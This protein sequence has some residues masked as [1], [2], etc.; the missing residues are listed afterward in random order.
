MYVWWLRLN[1]QFILGPIPLPCHRCLLPFF[2]TSMHFAL[3]GRAVL[4]RRALGDACLNTDF[5]LS[6]RDLAIDS[7]ELLDII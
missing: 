1:I 7:L 2:E 4:A 3:T 6:A 5:T